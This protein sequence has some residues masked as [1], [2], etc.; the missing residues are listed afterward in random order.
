MTNPCY[1]RDRKGTPKNFCD[2]DFA[3][4][5]GELSSA[6]CLKTLVLMGHDRKP[7]RILQKILWLCSCDFFGFG[8][9][10][11]L[12]TTIT[13]RPRPILKHR[14][15]GCA[16]KTR[17]EFNNCITAPVRELPL[18]P[19]R[20]PWF[21]FP[22]L[23]KLNENPTKDSSLAIPLACHRNRFRASGPK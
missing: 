13:P 16:V 4:L 19:M 18:A 1:L 7:P 10:F 15:H 8:V 11:W 20:K 14:Y 12:L 17:T 2:K 22:F 23:L 9:L 5:S 3:E 21:S 6:I